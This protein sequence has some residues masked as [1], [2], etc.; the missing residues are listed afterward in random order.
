VPLPIGHKRVKRGE[1]EDRERRN[2]P[3]PPRRRIGAA[4]QTPTGRRLPAA[5]SALRR[6]VHAEPVTRS[7][8]DGQFVDLLRYKVPTRAVPRSVEGDSS[9]SD[10][11]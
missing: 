6:F 1:R 9:G 8:C 5:V 7:R 10:G 11:P 4:T 3:P 2:Y